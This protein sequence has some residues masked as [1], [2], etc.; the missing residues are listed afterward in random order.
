MRRDNPS[1]T[2]GDP[3]DPSSSASRDV[4]YDD[5]P[6]EGGG[7]SDATYVG[8]TTNGVPVFHDQ[9]A[10][11]HGVPDE[12][13]RR[14]EPKPDTE[15]RLEPGETLGDVLEEIGESLGWESLS[16]YGREHQRDE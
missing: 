2:T 1:E 11:F 4:R 5:W 3:N 8:A 15:R 14:I 7:H 6:V 12:E 16:E 10:V 9:G 13:N